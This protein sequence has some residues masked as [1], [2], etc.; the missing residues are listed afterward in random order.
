MYTFYTDKPTNFECNI[1]LQ[2]A[3]LTKSKA[4]LVLE[5]D[6][7]N[8]I[9]YGTIDSDGK[10]T[11]PVSKL[12]NRLDENTKG[13]AKLEVIAE[14]TYFEPWED[15]FEVQTNKKVTVEVKNDTKK[16]MVESTEKKVKVTVKQNSKMNLISEEFLAILKKYKIDGFNINQNKKMLGNISNVFIKR[17]NLNES[18]Q[19]ELINKVI[20][21]LLK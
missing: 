19:K 16:P 3:K 8:Y 11:I 12:R 20:S 13:T 5:S 18:Q 14:D 4:R 15:S 7:I 10:C 9:F 17:Y 1:S 2:G 6:D 21:N